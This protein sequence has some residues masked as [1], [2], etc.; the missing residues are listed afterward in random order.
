MELPRCRRTRSTIAFE[1]IVRR[2]FPVHTENISSFVAIGRGHEGNCVPGTL[3]YTN[4]AFL[5]SKLERC[6]ENNRQSITLGRAF[7]RV[8]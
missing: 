4:I 5:L 1:S 8:K 7:N 6:A 3:E 2:S